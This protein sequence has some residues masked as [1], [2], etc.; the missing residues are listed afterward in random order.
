M[1]DIALSLQEVLLSVEVSNSVCF[2]G[3]PLVV[4][5]PMILKPNVIPMI[6][7]VGCIVSM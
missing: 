7:A 3:D 4:C 1:Y 2:A 5:C 6:G